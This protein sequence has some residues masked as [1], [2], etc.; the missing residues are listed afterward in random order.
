MKSRDKIAY[1]LY[2]TNAVIAIAFGL[3][4]ASCETVMPYHQQAIGLEWTELGLG[5]QILLNGFMKG[6]ASAFFIVGA[7]SMVLLLIPFRKGEI[8]SKWLIPFVQIASLAPAVYVSIN[9]ASKTQASTPWP[10]A[11]AT[12]GITI[13]AFLVSGVFLKTDENTTVR[14]VTSI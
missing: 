13:V 8:W 7:S 14:S 6:T 5:L 10:V 2:M 11:I 3:R 1:V 9:I 4:Y 12:A